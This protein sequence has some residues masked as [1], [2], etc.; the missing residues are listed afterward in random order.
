[1]TGQQLKNL[2]HRAMLSQL[3][4]ACMLGVNQVTVGNWER[5]KEQI[6]EGRID[7]IRRAIRESTTTVFASARDIEPKKIKPPKPMK[8]DD[9]LCRTGCKHWRPL[10]STIDSNF[11]T[12]C[13]HYILDTGHPRGCKPGK[14]CTRYDRTTRRKRRW[15]EV[16]YR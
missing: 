8:V 7:Q 1:M 5:E 4:L 11:A 10:A 6:P 15:T 13:C 2:R 3:E 14:D 16:L 12:R 9:S